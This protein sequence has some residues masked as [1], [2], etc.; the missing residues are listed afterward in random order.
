[1]GATKFSDALRMGAEVYQTLRTI[2]KESF[3]PAAINV[4]MKVDS[5]RRSTI[6]GRRWT[7]S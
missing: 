3:G 4:G 5:H 2:L 1:V 6:P 7:R